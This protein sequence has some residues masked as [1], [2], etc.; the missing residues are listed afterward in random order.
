MKIAIIGAGNLG[1]AIAK[2]IL[3]TNGATTMYLTKRKTGSIEKFEKY[4]N[5]TVTSNNREA[6]TNADILIFAVQPNQFVNILEEVKDLLTDKHVLISTITGFSIAQIE[7]IV[8]EDQNIIR[9]MP[10]T[11]ISVGKSMTCICA[12][13]RGKK[14]IE[15]ALA[16]FNRMGYSMEIPESQMQAATVI[17]ASGIA[18]WMRMIR[19]TTQGAIQLG[20]DAKEAQELAMHTCN[21]AA[22]LLIESGSHPEAEIDRVTTPQGCTIQGL[23]EMEHQGLSSSLIQGIVASYDKISRIKEGNM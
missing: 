10:N 5:V 19:A 23:N 15:L 22:A 2:G 11:A 18:F 16:I 1:L 14:R 7:A 9:S 6:V 21:G 13:E 3:A 12:N 8:G 17:C 4:G 20:F